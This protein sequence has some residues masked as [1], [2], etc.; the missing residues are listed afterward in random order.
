MK[1][2]VVSDTHGYFDPSLALLFDG[3]KMILHAGDIGSDPVLPNLRSIAPVLAIRGNIDLKLPTREYPDWMIRNIL[4]WRILIVHHLGKPDALQEEVAELISARHPHIVI[5]GHSHKFS[6]AEQ[7]RR[8]FL[9]PGSAG[10]KRF[11]LERSAAI[12]ELEPGRLSITI[13]SLER[14]GFPAVCEWEGFSG[15]L[16]N[17]FTTL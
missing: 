1:V 9:N 7:S 16:S 15:A 4:G 11:H 13:R 17:A 12:M 14:S 5:S 2:G 8:I 3:V 6:L 10:R